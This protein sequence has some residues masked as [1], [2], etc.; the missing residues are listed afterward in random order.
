MIEAGS[1]HPARSFSWRRRVALHGR[2]RA[3]C[4]S[5][6]ST[7]AAAAASPANSSTASS[8]RCACGAGRAPPT[9]SARRWACRSPRPTTRRCSSISHSTTRAWRR[10]PRWSSRARTRGLGCWATAPAPRPAFVAS[11]APIDCCRRKRRARGGRTP[12]PARATRA[13][14]SW[15]AAATS[16]SRS[17]GS[18]VA[19]VLAAGIC[20]SAAAALVRADYQTARPG[21]GG[22]ADR[23]DAGA[24]RG[25][26]M[27]QRR[28]RRH[29][30]G[31]RRDADLR[32]GFGR[33]LCMQ[34]LASARRR[35]RTRASSKCVGGPIVSAFF[36]L[37]ARRR[38]LLPLLPGPQ[39]GDRSGP[40][41]LAEG[42]ALPT[43]RAW[44][45][46]RS[47]SYRVG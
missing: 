11:D 24:D 44:S 22:A 17:C 16:R 38:R 39:G 25:G 47:S 34:Q 15:A 6:A 32:I 28:V 37:R 35:S 40:R 26:R 3:A 8:T 18:V 36:G 43:P 4:R 21:A 12:R 2:P 19:A 30:R 31:R 9:R 29:R 10:R 33:S 7:R 42:G 13:P 14:R 27:A 20:A 45:T 23:R 41:D 1:R 5:R 46:S